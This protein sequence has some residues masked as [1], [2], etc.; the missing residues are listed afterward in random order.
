MGCFSWMDCKKP[1]KAIRIGTGP[2]YVL[3][4]RE[5]QDF[6]GPCIVESCYNG[7]GSFGGHDA[8]ELIAIWNREYASD[9][10]IRGNDLKV[11][12]FGGLYGFEKEE[13]MRMGKSEDEIAEIDYKK[14]KKSY[15]AAVA[16][17]QYAINRLNDFK[18][19]KGLDTKWM[20]EKYG[21]DFLREIGS[22]IGCYDDQNRA[23]KWPFKVTYDKNA[24]YE[25]CKP[26]D[27]DPNQGF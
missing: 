10:N 22:S 2:V 24:D 17:R 20:V 11:E 27:G 15:D 23:L 18:S 7:Y 25:K 5:F 16:R 9:E 14:R 26:S 21:K 4:P 6:Y 13:L 8:Y 3:V 19:E 1:K 12:Q